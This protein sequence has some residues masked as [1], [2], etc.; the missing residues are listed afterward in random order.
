MSS[1]L[2][3]GNII[4]KTLDLRLRGAG[5]T[6]GRSADHG[7][8]V[9]KRVPLSPINVNCYQPNGSDALRLEAWE[10]LVPH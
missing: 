5:S 9:H 3:P 8:V 1:W 6:P 2:R 10:G 7:Q 4:V